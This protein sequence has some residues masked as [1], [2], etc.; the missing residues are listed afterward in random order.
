VTPGI[1]VIISLDDPSDLP[2]L[3]RALF[4]LFCQEPAL[5]MTVHL[6]LARFSVEDLL[7]LRQLTE[8]LRGLAADA[9]I[10]IHNWQLP[11][12]LNVRVPILNWGIEVTSHRYLT[13]L[14]VSDLLGPGA[15]GLLLD[16]LRE[17]G[18]A[19]IAAPLADQ[20]VEWWGDSFVPIVDPIAGRLAQNSGKPGLCF[21]LDRSQVKLGDLVFT[22][23]E[24]PH[25]VTGLIARITARYPAA[26]LPPGRVIGVRQIPN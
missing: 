25:E 12:P 15:Y 1:D 22:T 11:K 7:W 26:S 3:D 14:E 9:A 18:N 4:T 8:P 24:A 20:H 19:I 5:P 6:M 21:L 16:R 2:R 23:G 17:T 10:L 13:I